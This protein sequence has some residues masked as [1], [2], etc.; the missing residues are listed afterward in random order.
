MFD[1]MPIRD[2]VSWNSMV[3]GYAKVGDLE[4]AMEL[5]DRMPERNVVS[6]NVVISGCLRWR[7]TE[8]ALGLVRRVMTGE[9][10]VR[11]DVRTMVCAAT[12]CGRM[13]RAW[14]G[15][16][17]H[18]YF[19]KNF[20]REEGDNVIFGTALVDMYGKCGKVGDATK[21]FDGLRERNL[22]CWNAMIVGCCV[23]GDL[24]KGIALFEEM[25]KKGNVYCTYSC[26]ISIFA[27][28]NF[29]IYHFREITL[30]GIMNIILI[31][32]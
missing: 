28:D 3:D 31:H 15:R 22:V 12:G 23:H 9:G 2:L 27:K 10:R 18:G 6:W 29:F 17:V 24:K 20:V 30:L 4:E 14:E 7:R 26:H 25:V 32:M 13:G 11:G 19:L 21:V 1:E 16:S 8:M 5:F